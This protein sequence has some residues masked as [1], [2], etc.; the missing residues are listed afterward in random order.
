MAKSEL[1][2]IQLLMKLIGHKTG[3]ISKVT[4]TPQKIA[5]P[6]DAD[7]ETSLPRSTPEEQ[8]VDSAF[9]EK[10]FRALYDNNKCH[11]HKI[12]AVR[13]GHVIGECAFKP[14]DMDYWHVTH[15]MCKSVTGMAIGL[16]VYEGKIKLDDKIEDIFGKKGPLSYIFSKG[17]TV[18][19]LLTMSSG[20]EFNESGSVLCNDW[21]KQFLE[22][23]TKFTPG[24]AF[25]YNS[26]NSYMLSAIV[27]EVTGESMFD[28]L[29]PRIFEPLGIK[30]AFWESCPQNI[31]K[32]G[33]G[34]YLR[35]EDMAK[36]GQLYL[37]N[38]TYDGKVILPEEWVKES[39][40]MQIATGEVTAPGYGF[41]LW[42]SSSR[43]GAYTFNGMLGQNV[44]VFPDVNMMIVTNAGNEDL[45]QKGNMSGT[46]H[47]LMSEINVINEPIEMTEEVLARQNSLKEFIRK[48]EDLPKQRT[49]IAGGGWNKKKKRNTFGMSP[50]FRH[51]F[52]KCLDGITYDMD[53]VG[54]GFMPLLVQVMHNNYTDG[55]K[56]IGF[57]LDDRT[58]AFYLL[59]RE[60]D[61]VHEIKCGFDGFRAVTEIDEHGEIYSISTVSEFSLDEY[62]RPVLR[63]EF[64]LL[65]DSTARVM[66]VYFGKREPLQHDIG[67]SLEKMNPPV[68]IGIR[69]DEIPGSGMLIGILNQFG[70]LDVGKGMSGFVINRLSD[71]GAIDALMLAIINTVRPK[72]HGVLHDKES[73]L[74]YDSNDESQRD[75]EN[76]TIDDDAI[77]EDD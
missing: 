10:L 42:N 5:F 29:K 13:N 52:M 48:A 9:I 57:K 4:Y 56:S 71:Y 61:T 34:L 55:I 32:G 28:Y 70:H 67:F 38:G 19:H 23:S 39:T 53:D 49:C 35:L 58:G 30:R 64:Y 7:G 59:I 11:M 46:V 12:M 54:V 45:F 43:I 69:F 72:L 33:W 66:N 47:K 27:T 76:I 15:S 2:L 37:N 68:N 40:T 16:L 24:T 26:M 14:F 8:G 31:T 50:K 51:H 63:N 22:S 44:Y 65:E 1:E 77:M 18:R 75:S 74:E 20:V 41:Q 17:L 3:E 62:N 60:G 6:K 73:S 25:E 36:L 21:K